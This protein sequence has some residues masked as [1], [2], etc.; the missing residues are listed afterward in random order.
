M[1][2]LN[3]MLNKKFAAAVLVASTSIFA[4]AADLTVINTG[5]KTGGFFRSSNALQQD[6]AKAISVEYVNPGQYCAAYAVLQKTTGPVLFPWANDFEAAG[7]SGEGCATIPLKAEEIVSYTRDT[8]RVCSAKPEMTKER[9]V[10]AGESARVGY[11]T[12]AFAFE[13]TVQAVNKSFGTKHVGV[14]YEAGGGAVKTALLNKEVDYVILW[15][16]FA[17]EVTSNGTANCF[18]STGT[19]TLDGM[20][21]IASKDT[22]NKKLIIGSD[23]VWLLKNATPAQAASISKLV[24]A[25]YGDQNSAITAQIK[26]SSPPNFNKSK[27][28]IISDWEDAVNALKK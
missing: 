28:S 25:A 5:S 8:Y 3:R 26:K 9:F 20:E 11:S 14:T 21:G 16:S 17:Q 19:E 13:N 10:K 22:A 2:G 1:K 27:Q 18:W 24:Q 15:P 23:T 6:L 12:P 4:Q 7:R